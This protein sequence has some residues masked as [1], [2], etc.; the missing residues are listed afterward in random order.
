MEAVRVGGLVVPA[1][2]VCDPRMAAALYLLGPLWPDPRLAAHLVCD[3]DAD[4]V[5]IDFRRL[6]HDNDWSSPERLIV[7]AAAA[8]YGGYSADGDDSL[9]AMV[10]ILNPAQLA[11]VQ[12]AIRVRR[13]RM[14]LAEAIEAE[15]SLIDQCRTLGTALL[16]LWDGMHVLGDPGLDLDLLHVAHR[17][18]TM[19]DADLLETVPS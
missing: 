11:R 12:R 16:E 10:E 4:V 9:G 5:Q 2:V 3:A 18:S 1:S 7:G 14:S 19:S 8:L 6:L 17:L 15:P 13:R